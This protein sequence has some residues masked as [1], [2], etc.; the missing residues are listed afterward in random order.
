MFTQIISRPEFSSGGD[1]ILF[2][3]WHE[4]ILSTDN[5]RS[6]TVT[7]GCGRRTATLVIGP[8]VKAGYQSTIIYHNESVLKTVYAAMG[9]SPCP[10]AAKHA[11]PM[12]DFFKTS[13]SSENP[14]HSIVTSTPGN[15]ATV[16]GAVHLIATA[17]ESRTVS[18]T[19][20]LG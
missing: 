19:P 4:G 11:D 3:V 17:S 10:G 20:S 14:S 16:V 7:E 15:G 8:Q 1:A 12:A 18:Q 6:A 2:I 5:R 9:L 13:T